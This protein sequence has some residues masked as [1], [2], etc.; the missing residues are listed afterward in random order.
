MPVTA[1]IVFWSVAVNATTSSGTRRLDAIWNHRPVVPALL[2]EAPA[3]VNVKALSQSL[4]W[5]GCVSVSSG[6]PRPL[7]SA[8][9]STMSYRWVHGMLMNMVGNV[10]INFGTNLLKLAHDVN[11][12]VAL[13]THIS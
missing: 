3:C 6:D 11:R 1:G 9:F 10:L 13:V 4:E 7:P 8:N 12:L 5:R 2:T